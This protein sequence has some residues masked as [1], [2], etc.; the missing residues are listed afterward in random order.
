MNL[1]K[2]LDIESCDK[3]MSIEYAHN[4]DWQNNIII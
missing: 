4:H 2:R 1:K 3:L